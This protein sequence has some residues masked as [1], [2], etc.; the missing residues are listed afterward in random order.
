[1]RKVFISHS[2]LD[3]LFA[4]RLA[5][6]LGKHGLDVWYSEW[7]MRP[8]DSLTQKVAEGITSSGSM[9][10][11]LS[12][13]SVQSP[14]VEK[15]LSLALCSKLARQNVQIFPVLLETCSFP[16]SFHFIGDTL[17]ADFRDD[18][19]RALQR[20]L[21]AL[22]VRPGRRGI[23]LYEGDASL[24]NVDQPGAITVAR[25]EGL[26]MIWEF[27]RLTESIDLT[28]EHNGATPQWP[29]LQ[30][31]LTKRQS[32]KVR[33]MRENGGWGYYDLVDA[34]G[35]YRALINVAFLTHECEPLTFRWLIDGRRRRA[36]RISWDIF[37]GQ[38]DPTF[39]PPYD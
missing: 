36:L 37:G 8:G 5:K 1:V 13:N 2:H 29:L 17:Y 27:D 35:P 4:E 14:W 16:K 32:S 12:K 33:G 31:P 15:E 6:D 20:L 24:L 18:Y 10:V 21:S 28:L 25:W 19:N 3:Q 30:V 34:I 38:D 23:K 39:G 9:V 11:L 7:Q 22:G 26:E